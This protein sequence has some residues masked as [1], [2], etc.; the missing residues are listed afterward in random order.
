MCSGEGMSGYSQRGR[1]LL[2]CHN[3]GTPWG[4]P[5]TC[6]STNPVPK[7]PASRDFRNLK[8]V[9]SIRD[10]L[11]K[12]VTEHGAYTTQTTLTLINFVQC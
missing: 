8:P 9:R 6:V 2:H 3:D 4:M 11:Q 5:R 12:A 10:A 1:G 7:G